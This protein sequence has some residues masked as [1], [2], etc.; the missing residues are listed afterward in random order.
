MWKHPFFVLYGLSLLAGGTIAEYR[1]WTLF[2]PT[3]VRGVPK[4]IRDN[5]GIYRSIYAGYGRYSG[6]K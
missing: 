1:G 5:P 6:G 3:E 2:Q 4:T